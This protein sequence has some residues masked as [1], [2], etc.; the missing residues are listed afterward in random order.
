MRET[1]THT[2]VK[3]LKAITTTTF[4]KFLFFVALD[5]SICFLYFPPPAHPQCIFSPFDVECHITR[6]PTFETP[7]KKR[8]EEEE[9]RDSEWRMIE[10]LCGNFCGI[11]IFT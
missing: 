7:R 3:Y 6:L 1:H 11:L 9:R 2:H 8:E 5:S 4:G 10:A